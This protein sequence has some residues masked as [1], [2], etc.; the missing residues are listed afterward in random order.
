MTDLSFSV[1]GILPTVV[2]F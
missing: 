1:D 2:K